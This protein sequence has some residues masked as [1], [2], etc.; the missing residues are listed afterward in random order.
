MITDSL[1]KS[2]GRGR[3]PKKLLN[4]Y[5]AWKNLVLV[6]TLVVMALSALPTWYGEDAAVQ[7]SPKA[8]LGLISDPDSF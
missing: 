2:N 5:S 8:G 4:H 1:L 6:V 7:I 3:Q